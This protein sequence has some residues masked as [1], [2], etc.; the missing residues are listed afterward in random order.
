M[1]LRSCV[2]QSPLWL[3]LR[4]PDHPAIL[5]AD[6]DAATYQAPLAAMDCDVFAAR[7][8]DDLVLRAADLWPHVIVMDVAKDDAKGWQ[9][10]VG[11]RQSSWTSGIRVIAVSDDD[12]GR[13]SAFEHGCD[14]FLTKPF[15]PQI[16]RAQIRA[17][18]EPPEIRTIRRDTPVVPIRPAA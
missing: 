14:A 1:P 6:R 3:A 13:E 11:L 7:E 10:I 9:A 2:D 12:A 17:L 16:L 8:G 4:R 18:I 5:I 15:T